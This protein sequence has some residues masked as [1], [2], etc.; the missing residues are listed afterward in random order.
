[1]SGILISRSV[2]EYYI[3]FRKWWL[4]LLIGVIVLLS[5]IRLL[6]YSISYYNRQTLQYDGGWV[7]GLN[8]NQLVIRGCAVK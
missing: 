6:S 1:M 5:Q 3:L 4:E 8:V 2:T 7:R